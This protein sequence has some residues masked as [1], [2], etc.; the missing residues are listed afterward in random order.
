ME[1]EIVGCFEIGCKS[2]RGPKFRPADIR[3]FC[4]KVS[5]AKSR[6]QWLVEIQLITC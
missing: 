2:D 4:I 3:M 5:A 6:E 1:M